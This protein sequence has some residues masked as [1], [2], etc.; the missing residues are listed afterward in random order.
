MLGQADDDDDVLLALQG[1]RW[2]GPARAWATVTPVALDRHPGSL[3]DRDPRRRAKAEGRAEATVRAACAR[4]GLAEPAEVALSRQGFVRGV[5][6]VPAFPAFTSNTDGGAPLKRYL[7][8]ARLLFDQAVHGPVVI[9]AGR[10]RGL[11]LCLPLHGD[12]GGEHA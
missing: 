1:R 8:H 4:I 5:L 11:G 3:G 9:G 12:Q 6:P 7:V 2:A 10:Y